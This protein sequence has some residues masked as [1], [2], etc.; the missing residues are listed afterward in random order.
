MQTCM[1]AALNML[2][3]MQ[4]ADRLQAG[5][6]YKRPVLASGTQC[7]VCRRWPEV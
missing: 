1:R 6:A 4:S 5:R 7:G 2:S 3:H